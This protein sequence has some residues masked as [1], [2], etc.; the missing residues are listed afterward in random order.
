MPSTP[1]YAQLYQIYT[2]VYLNQLVAQLGHPV[3][4]DDIP[5]Q[6]LQDLAE[7]GFNW[8]YLMGVW[9]T[10]PAARQIALNN[11]PLRRELLA[12]YPGL[13]DED[14]VSSCFAITG[15][16]AHPDFGGLEALARL[17][18]RMAAYGLRLMLDFIPN[19]VAVDHP[20]AWE[21][22]DYIVQGSSDDLAAH[23]DIYF[24]ADTAQGERILAHG[25]DPYFPA[26]NDTL[27]L[28]YS[29][30]DLIEAMTQ[31]LLGVARLCDGV[32][33]DMAMLVL[34]EVF[35]RTW[36]RPSA[37]SFWEPAIRRARAEQP[38]FTCLAEV[39]WHM[40]E[41]LIQQGFDFTYDKRYYDHLIRREL[42]ALHGHLH[43]PPGL[44]AHMAHFLENHDEPRAALELAS[45]DQHRAAATLA[46]LVPGLRF[47]QHGQLEGWRIHTPMQLARPLEDA[48]D[49]AVQALYVRLLACLKLPAIRQGEWRLLE[50]DTG[51]VDNGRCFPV[52]GF[53]W[54]ADSQAPVLCVVNYAPEPAACTLRPGLEGLRGRRWRLVDHLGGAVWECDGDELLDQ[55]FALQLL[56]WSAQVLEVVPAGSEG[57]EGNEK[58]PG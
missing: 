23:P 37:G 1:P 26:W 47:I 39:Y 11:Q 12:I 3:C 52:F 15:Y 53:V 18:E 32:R 13:M 5:D 56:G 20:W 14:I 6:A 30:P 31:E 17:R 9:K 58:D 33:C 34:P 40:E 41:T 21:H 10:G 27:Q 25:R 48:P 43:M 28:N 42:D 29:N 7:Q 4:L 2:R 54:Q 50:L 16:Q 8:I 19:H 36:G 24:K 46:Y 44:L 57:S 22:P 49:E 51:W 35:Q 55:G 45:P 38:G